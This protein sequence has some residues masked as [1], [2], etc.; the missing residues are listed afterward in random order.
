M[1]LNILNCAY[2]PQMVPAG[3]NH[4]ILLVSTYFRKFQSSSHCGLNLEASRVS[5]HFIILLPLG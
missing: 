4:Q 2:L 3:E 5:L 1:A